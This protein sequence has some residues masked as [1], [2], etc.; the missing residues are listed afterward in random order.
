MGLTAAFI[1]AFYSWRLLI[2]TF[3]GKSRANEKVLSHVHESPAIM[4]VPLLIL[5]IG[6]IGAGYVFYNMFVGD[7]RASFW[8]TSLFVLEQNDTIEAAH[9]VPFWVKKAPLVAAVS[10]ILIATLIYGF[11]GG[12]ARFI[13]RVFKPIHTLFFNK[14]FFDELYDKVFVRSALWFGRLFSTKGDQSII[15]RMGPDGLAS[16]SQAIARAL[17]SIQTGYVYHYAFV[18]ILGLVGVLS[19]IF[20]KMVTAL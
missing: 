14:Y 10:G 1:T 3:H 7:D 19:W 2:M 20:Y 8:A 17:S 6:A 11:G 9:H 4:I 13:A 5:S 18:M 16:R 15:N 12:F